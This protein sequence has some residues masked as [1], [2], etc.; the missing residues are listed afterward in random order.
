MSFFKY[1]LLPLHH[2]KLWHHR[3]LS[4]SS[5][6]CAVKNGHTVLRDRGV[7]VCEEIWAVWCD[8]ASLISPMAFM[9]RATRRHL[10]SLRPDGHGA[11]PWQLCWGYMPICPLFVCPESVCLPELWLTSIPSPSSILLIVVSVVL[12]KGTD[13]TKWGGYMESISA[14]TDQQT[15]VWFLWGAVHWLLQYHIDS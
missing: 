2:Q 15:C 5:A 7:Y 13:K 11:L 1:T 10:L 14:F 8:L 4:S 6:R 3:L 9:E 12:W